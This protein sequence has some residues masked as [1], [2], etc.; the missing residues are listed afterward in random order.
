LS[1]MRLVSL[2]DNTQV[3]FHKFLSLEENLRLGALEGAFEGLADGI[4][5][6]FAE[7]FVVGNVVGFADGTAWIVLTQKVTT[8]SRNKC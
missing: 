7:G 6:G 5:V 1:E 4:I 3:R 2:E 8:S